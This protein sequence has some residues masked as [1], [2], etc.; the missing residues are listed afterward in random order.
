MTEEERKAYMEMDAR[1]LVRVI[2]GEELSEGQATR[3]LRDREKAAK[4][5]LPLEPEGK[6]GASVGG[7]APGD[8]EARGGE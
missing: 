1:I 8:Y 5:S 3:I 2:R 6:A 7:W 4:A